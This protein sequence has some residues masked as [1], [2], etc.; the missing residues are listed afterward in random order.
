MRKKPQE[1]KLNDLRYLNEELNK[2][3]IYGRHDLTKYAINEL[4]KLIAKEIEKEKVEAQREAEREQKK[5]E[6]LQ[7]KNDNFGLE[8]LEFEKLLGSHK[9]QNKPEG[10]AVQEQKLKKHQEKARER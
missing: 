6:R 8:F 7:T 10:T 9:T 4:N 1:R 3:I 2:P 5:A